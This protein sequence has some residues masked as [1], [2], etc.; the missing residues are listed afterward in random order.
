MKKLIVLLWLLFAGHFAFSQ[1]DSPLWW[2]KRSVSGW[3][4]FS[5]KSKPRSLE[6]IA[7]K[8]TENNGKVEKGERS[9]PFYVSLN[10]DFYLE[11][12]SLGRTTREKS[13]DEGEVRDL[14]HIYDAVK[15]TE[16]ITFPYNKGKYY[17][18]TVYSYNSA[19]KIS[20][21]FWQSIY[22]YGGNGEYHSTLTKKFDGKGNE[23]E[24]DNVSVGRD[25]SINT[26]TRSY[27]NAKNQLIC[28]DGYGENGA[29]WNRQKNT[30]DLKGRCIKEE[31]YTTDTTKIEHSMTYTYNDQG[32]VIKKEYYSP[33][34]KIPSKIFTYEYV[35]DKQ[36][37]WI[38]RTDYE[39]GKAT[40][41]IERELMYY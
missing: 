9:H 15:N 40:A 18:K 17:H 22:G 37:N 36:G 21:V 26:K 30:Y 31:Y 3:D 16:S 4:L 33:P 34:L 8:V 10:G 2:G 24:S 39:N 25:E 13:S 20:K 41:I 35:Y 23:I 1:F 27:Y 14:A 5:L 38:R 7:Y 6:Q 28:L 19:G 32:S 12:D 11:F 29:F